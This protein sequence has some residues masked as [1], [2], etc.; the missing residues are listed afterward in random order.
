ML[1][2]ITPLHT[3]AE[4]DCMVGL[5]VGQLLVRHKLVCSV[6]AVIILLP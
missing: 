5:A 4:S 6:E 1:L 2:E 3:V